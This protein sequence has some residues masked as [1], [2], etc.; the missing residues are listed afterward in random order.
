MSE[1]TEITL[2]PPG[3]NLEGFPLPTPSSANRDMLAIPPQDLANA[4]ASTSN[5][6]TSRADIW[7]NL[8]YVD[9]AANSVEQIIAFTFRPNSCYLDRM[10]VLALLPGKLSGQPSSVHS[11]VFPGWLPR[12]I[13]SLF[14]QSMGLEGEDTLGNICYSNH[15]GQ[16]YEVYLHFLSVKDLKGRPDINPAAII[17]SIGVVH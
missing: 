10:G 1:N 15:S 9:H 12:D 4:R 17:D 2:P 14:G 11:R 6:Q 16:V 8:N 5:G 13:S 7:S 3:F